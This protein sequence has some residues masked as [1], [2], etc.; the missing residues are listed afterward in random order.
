MLTGHLIPVSGKRRSILAP[1]VEARQLILFQ[2]PPQPT[3][4]SPHFH[5]SITPSSF[6]QPSLAYSSAICAF[7]VAASHELI[8]ANASS[9][10]SIRV[11]ADLDETIALLKN[12]VEKHDGVK[13][14]I[15]VSLPA[16]VLDADIE[17]FDTIVV[18]YF[19]VPPL[20]PGP[21]YLIPSTR[22]T[23][24]RCVDRANGRMFLI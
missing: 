3:P 1:S 23:N 4:L 22:I 19:T 18:S 10:L 24:H 12:T 6:A 8:V 5:L 9:L 13:L 2:V 15:E 16:V 20:T 7:L 17:G 21:P 14:S 11:A